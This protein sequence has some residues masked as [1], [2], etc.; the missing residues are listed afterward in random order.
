MDDLLS[1]YRKHLEVGGRLSPYTIR[2][3]VTDVKEFLDFLSRRK[4]SPDRVA[5]EVFRDYLAELHGKGR[6]RASLARKLSALRSFYRYLEVEK[7]WPD[8]MDGVKSP[9]LER[10]LPS[11][12]NREEIERLLSAPD[13]ATPAGLRDRALLELLYASGLRVS[14]AA[15]L[16]C[17]QVDL[18]SG[19]IRVRGKGNKERIALMGRPAVRA[20]REYLEKGRPQLLG[21]SRSPFLFINYQGKGLTPRGIQKLVREYAVKAGLEKRVHPHLLRHT[22]ATH[23]LDGSADLRVVQ[24]LLGHASLGSTQVYTHV[25]RS[26][27]RQVYLKAHPRARREDEGTGDQ[28]P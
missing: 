17:S 16:E 11:Y 27:I 2:N 20:L 3:Y 23:L 19:E 9:K 26:H 1:E 22:F 5:R 8:P 13:P 4:I 21:E 7:G 24:E 10:R 15:S 6:V 14:E 25:S 18:E 12:L 28:R